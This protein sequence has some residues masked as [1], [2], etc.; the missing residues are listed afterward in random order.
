MVRLPFGMTLAGCLIVSVSMEARAQEKAGEK[1]PIADKDLRA[2]YEK[3]SPENKQS[4]VKVQQI[5]LKV[6]RKDLDPQVEQ[7]A[8]D[9]VVKSASVAHIASSDAQHRATDA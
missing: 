4:G 6:A 9:L 2:E 5:L 8:K 3:L 1:I 7:K